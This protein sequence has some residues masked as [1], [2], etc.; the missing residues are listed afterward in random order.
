MRPNY[1]LKRTVQSLRDWS[2]RLAHA[3]GA[4]DDR[5]AQ[6]F[7]EPQVLAIAVPLMLFGVLVATLMRW[8]VIAKLESIGL[9][10]EK[11]REFSHLNPDGLVYW[12]DARL[13]RRLFGQ[14]SSVLSSSERFWLSFYCF[15]RVVGVTASLVMVIDVLARK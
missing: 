7:R 6:Q 10:G 9:R 2:C 5:P 4:C 8:W 11:G 1:S 15:G 12:F 3:L 13:L 14:E